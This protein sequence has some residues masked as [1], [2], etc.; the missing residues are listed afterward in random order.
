M[1]E[2]RTNEHPLTL[3]TVLV[4]RARSASD[5]RLVVDA[6]GGLITSVVV[7]VLHPPGWPVIASAAFCFLA[8]GVW[9]ISDRTIRERDAGTRGRA[10]HV[11]RAAAA[12]IGILGAVALAISAMFLMLGTWIS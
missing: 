10:L 9:G 8:F 7:L 3:A 6:A 11:L 2:T 4:R 5:G 1:V 12:T